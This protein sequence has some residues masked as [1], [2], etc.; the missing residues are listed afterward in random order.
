[1]KKPKSTS[2]KV[3]NL[4]FWPLI[5]LV[6][7]IITITTIVFYKSDRLHLF[8][9]VDNT[10][11]GQFGDFI[12]GVAGTLINLGT[13]IFLY[14]NYKE[15]R[16]ANAENAELIEKQTK[17]FDAQLAV[18][19][20]D[21]ERYLD[22]IMPY[23]KLTYE[24]INKGDNKCTIHIL[25]ENNPGYQASICLTEPTSD[26]AKINGVLANRV[27]DY[28][29]GVD[30]TASIE[31]NM[32]KIAEEGI[33]LDDLPASIEVKFS[34]RLAIQYSQLFCIYP[35]TYFRVIHWVPEK[36]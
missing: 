25:F 8:T 33:V 10:I 6:T 34:N 32:E 29:K 7:A 20:R 14:I 35:F 31:F 19:E 4:I 13:V 3:A 2:L 26:F 28:N 21:Y 1:M 24:Q 16:K 22:Q 30:L 27:Y 5:T 36:V 15:Q 12:A 23:V 9:P 11:F 17:A 18:A